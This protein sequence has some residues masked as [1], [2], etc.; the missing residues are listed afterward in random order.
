MLN[1][2][3]KDVSKYC[4]E[5]FLKQHN[6]YFCDNDIFW[7]FVHVNILKSYASMLNYNIESKGV[8]EKKKTTIASN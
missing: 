2:V 8:Y 6:W 5:M 4:Q 1:H 3:L 7:K